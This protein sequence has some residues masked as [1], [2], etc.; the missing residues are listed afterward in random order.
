M[1]RRTFLMGS[2][3]LAGLPGIS[4]GQNSTSQ[5]GAWWKSNDLDA[6]RIIRI[7]HATTE[8]V[9][10]LPMGNGD[11]GLMLYGGPE[12]LTLLLNKS[13]V[14]D[15]RI[16]P[17]QGL[18]ES[19]SFDELVELINRQDWAKAEPVFTNFRK[20]E[21]CS[22][23]SLQACGQLDLELLTGERP[24]GFHQQLDL[25]RAVG[26]IHCDYTEYLAGRQALDVRTFVPARDTVIPVWVRNVPGY[27]L[28]G[29]LRLWRQ[30]SLDFEPPEAWVDG[31][32]AGLNMSIPESL[33]YSIA[34]RVLGPAGEWTKTASEASFTLRPVQEK[35]LLLVTVVTTFEDPNPSQTAL[36]R[37]RAL[38]ANVPAQ[39][40]DAHVRWWND[41]WKRSSVSVPDVKLE[42]LWRAGMYFLGSSRQPGKQAPGLQGIWNGYNRPGWHT[43]YHTDM[44]VQ[45]S[46]WP[47]YTGNQLE[48]TEPFNRLFAVEMVKEARRQA[49]QFFKRPGLYIPLAPGPHGHE[50]AGPWMWLFGGA[51]VAQHYWWHYLYTGDTD[52]LRK[53]YPFLKDI[54]AFCESY[55]KKNEEGV[56]EIYPSQCPEMGYPG[57]PL[58]RVWGKNSAPDL[59]FSKVLFSAL[60][61]A[62]ELLDVDVA[63]RKRWADIRDHLAPY[64]LIDGH[65]APLEHPEFRKAHGG[66][67]ALSPIFP[68][69]AFGLGSAPELLSM[70]RRSFEAGKAR[71]GGHA[72]V[73]SAAIAARLGLA[74]EAVLLLHSYI[75]RWGLENG[76]YLLGPDLHSPGL[77]AGI[78]QADAPIAFATSVNE[79]LLQSL[80]GVIRVFPAVPNDWTAEFETLRAA[81]AFLVSSRVENGRTR[82]VRLLS[83]RGGPAVVQDPFGVTEVTLRV[84]G[85]GGGGPSTL[86]R[87]AGGTFR[88]D[89]T[90]GATYTLEA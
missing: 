75:E 56:Y 1:N 73:W 59:A 62:S 42:R 57:H 81:G 60:A 16:L 66:I 8:W 74:D 11:L 65:L 3:L 47:A 50:L 70:A 12:R 86:R 64:P 19:I 88:F 82:W 35:F 22:S 36:K 18:P 29:V 67:M 37:L 4:A 25:D 80:D 44:N 83:E 46:F 27:K 45:M 21:D 85:Q 32:T 58:M 53:Y 10:G 24:L 61:Q 54:A 28:F 43:D 23:P 84:S 78:M 14:W 39:L 71:N 7:D 89:T 30:H 76:L 26:S 63:D 49:Q 20:A 34:V 17:G 69:G 87:N 52:Y 77:S 15:F 6:R 41:F 90:A 2:T 55:I 31:D 72:T 68:A 33:K 38:D 5:S 51:W 40:E 48:L 9:E 13:N 79:M